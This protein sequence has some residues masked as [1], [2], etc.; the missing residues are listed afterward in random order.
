MARTRRPLVLVV[1]DDSRVRDVL[2]DALESDYEVATAADGAAGLKIFR[3]RPVDVVLL[4]LR[5]PGVGGLDVLRR[6]KAL[7]PRV[8]VILVTAVHD[9]GV[10]VEGMRAGAFD[11]ITKPFSLDRLAAVVARVI[12]QRLAGSEIVLVARE[13]GSWMALHVF[14]ERTLGTVVTVSAD[15]AAR[16]LAGRRPR[17]LVVDCP[18]YPAASIDLMKRLGRRYPESSFLAIAPDRSVAERLHGSRQL[19]EAAIVA[20]PVHLDTLLDRIAA[21]LGLAAQRRVAAPRLP[22]SVLTAAEYVSRHHRDTLHTEHLARAA[23]VSPIDLGRAFREAIGITPKDFVARFRIAAVCHEL[24]G[25][26]H[27]MEH[28]AATTGFKDASHLSRVFTRQLGVRPGEYRRRVRK[29]SA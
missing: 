26:K 23:A 7:D 17:L 13:T 9:I 8:D 1:E 24:I 29:M 27:P 12:D 19:A 4:D 3:R 21:Q 10:V 5:L 20:G 28:I 6:M 15:A 2:R 11:Y 25:S 22:T 16:G 18:S 14:I